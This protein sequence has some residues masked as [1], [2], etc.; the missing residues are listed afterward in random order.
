MSDDTWMARM[1]ARAHVKQA[2]E[3]AAA[4][5]R[6]ETREQAWQAARAATNQATIDAGPP[7]A[8]AACWV[9]TYSKLGGDAYWWHRLDVPWQLDPDQAGDEARLDWPVL[10]GYCGHWCHETEPEELWQPIPMACAG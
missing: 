6:M 1:A 9:I 2:T 3:R 7:D 4:Y 5:A 8:C 10:L